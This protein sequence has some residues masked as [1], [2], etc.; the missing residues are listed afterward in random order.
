M[1]NSNSCLLMPKCNGIDIEECSISQLQNYLTEG[2][3]TS[4]ELTG[5]YLK[6]IELINP[7]VKAVIETNPK[8]REIATTLDEER[9]NKI[10]RSKLHGIPFLVKDNIATKDKM[11]T[12][13]GCAA[14][15]GT[16]VPDDAR[17]VTL[18]REA[19][20]ILLGKANLSEWASLRASYYSEGYSSRGGQNRNP[21]N[22]S[23][24][25][26]RVQFWSASSVASNYVCI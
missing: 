25:P 21:Y 13:A 18:L 2:V 20:A 23:H 17:I 15:I 1:S 22:L 26:W 12:T 24:H 5:C 19:G 14:L 3:F 4:G 11:Q 16:I 7:Y 10:I 9:K 8:A 6:R